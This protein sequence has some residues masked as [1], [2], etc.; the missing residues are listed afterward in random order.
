MRSEINLFSIIIDILAIID[1]ESIVD[2]D[3]KK[4]LF[5]R[6]ESLLFQLNNKVIDLHFVI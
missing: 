5:V 4:I 1:I 6:R 3:L 2:K